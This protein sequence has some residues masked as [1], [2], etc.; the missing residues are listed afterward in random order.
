MKAVVEDLG[1]SQ[2]KLVFE[3][4]AEEVAE[5]IEK[6]CRKL[7]KEV[8]IKG[9]RKGKAPTSVIK[10]F[11]RE[12][13]RGEVV[14][15]IVS[16]S[17]EKALE[18]NSLTP[19]GEP[20]IDT[21][22]LEEGKSFP[23]TVTV[24]V[25][26]EIEVKDYQGIN[27]ET[28]PVAVTEEE[29]Q[30]ALEELRKVHAEL[31]GIEEDRGAVRGDVVLADYEGF[32]EERPVPGTENKD[33]QIEIGSGSFK[34]DVEEALIGV[35]P[36]ELR[37]V[38]IEYPANF[39]NK[40]IAGKKVQY[41]F[42]IKKISEKKLPELD[43]EFAK[44]VGAYEN[45][46]ALKERLRAEVGRE[47][48]VRARKK[49][50]EA[51]LDLILERNPFEAPRSLVKS[52][53]EQMIVD[54]RAHFLSQGIALEKESEGFQRLEAEFDQLA[55][56]EVKKRLVLDA[57]AR[58]EKLI[59]SDADLEQEI[60]RIAEK[61]NQS[62]EKVKAEMQKQEDGLERFRQSLQLMKTLDFLLPPVT[63]E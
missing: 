18:E 63:I 11:F 54:A 24:D 57:I 56:K 31:R 37:E 45:L 41:R 49:K 8:D 15:K 25:K 46:E 13:V 27:V 23:F 60:E 42:H 53:K 34:A 7:A 48:G 17:I 9:F 47:K 4:P 43:D 1:G 40:E 22:P 61:H 35:R 5:E 32:F 39:L 55:E 58:K 16:T 19:V 59:V 26:P 44:D 20:E 50:E 2:R 14:S 62:V 38:D 6:Y 3:V 28:E 36:G 29:I 30:K 52:R 21:P 33:A 12:Q 51:V 10:R